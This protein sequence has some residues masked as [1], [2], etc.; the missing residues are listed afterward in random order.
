MEI[1]GLKYSFLFA[2]PD[3]VVLIAASESSTSPYR[4]AWLQWRRTSSGSLCKYVCVHVCV[5]VFVYLYIH[6]PFLGSGSGVGGFVLG[7]LFPHFSVIH[8]HDAQKA[9][10]QGA[11]PCVK[12]IHLICLHVTFSTYFQLPFMPHSLCLRWSWGDY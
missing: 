10:F 6:P 12:F 11:V 2:R 5:C 3:S 4:L 1:S 8:K 9:H 7:S